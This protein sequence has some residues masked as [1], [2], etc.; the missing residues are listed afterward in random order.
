MASNKP[1]KASTPAPRMSTQD[2]VWQAEA[3]LRSL[4]SAAQVS[5]DPKRMAAAKKQAQEQITALASVAKR[6]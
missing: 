3:D 5:A 2:K 1:T 6:K 4:Q